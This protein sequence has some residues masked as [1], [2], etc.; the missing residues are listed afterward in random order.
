MKKV[1]IIY[2]GEA[3]TIETTINFFKNNV[4]LNDNYHVFAVIQSNNI[5]LH[6]NIIKDT[7]GE[8]LKSLNWFN[9]TDDNW[10]NLRETQLEKMNN[11]QDWTINYLRNSGSM[12]EY[13]QMYL[14]YKSLAQYEN[15]HNI[16]YDYVLRFRTDTVMKD[17]LD[18]DTMF[19]FDREYIK[20]LLY[21]IKEHNNLEN[22]I[23]FKALNILMG[24]FYNEKRLYYKNNYDQNK[25]LEK[26][27]RFLEI[28]DEDKYID[29]L[30]DYLKNG[31]YII[32]LRENII[33]FMKRE[34]MVHLNI[35]G[36][37][38][39]DYTLENDAYWWN[40]ESQL[41]LISYKNNIDFY[42]SVTDLEGASLYAYNHLNYFDENNNLLNTDFSFFIKRY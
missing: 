18:F 33:Y 14:A 24:V 23:S 21:K 27:Y 7:I 9:N 12:I 30:T 2:T 32:S 4:I 36:V 3:R 41:K 16:T 20:K 5:E 15:T 37:T 13:Y 42:G 39:G 40:A 8:N 28:S 29:S 11:C 34:L 19:N 10:I 35:L 6:N 17:K 26:I 1:A 25:I 22:I 31:N 38:Y